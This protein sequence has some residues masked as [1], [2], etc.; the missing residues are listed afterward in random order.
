MKMMQCFLIIL[1]EIKSIVSSTEPCGTPWLFSDVKI[2]VTLC[3]S[4]CS[5]GEL[6]SHSWTCHVLW[7]GSDCRCP[8]CGSRNLL[9][10]QRNRVT[11]N[12]R[13]WRLNKSEQFVIWLHRSWSFT[14]ASRE[15]LQINCCSLLNFFYIPIFYML[16]YILNIR[17]QWCEPEGFLFH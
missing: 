6:W 5:C 14:S 7:S 11:M 4:V 10:H 9:T 15:H 17:E 13:G 12:G 2:Y 16:Y 8:R 1:P 3:V